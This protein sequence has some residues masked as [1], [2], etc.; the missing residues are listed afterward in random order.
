MKK[1][2]SNNYPTK[3][4]LKAKD[5]LV[6]A[7]DLQWKI[8][9]EKQR[10]EREAEGRAFRQKRE[11]AA[12]S[13]YAMAKQSGLAYST[14]QRYEQ[15]KYVTRR[16]VVKTTLENALTNWHLIRFAKAIRSHLP[17]V[18]QEVMDAAEKSRPRSH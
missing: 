12:L 3:M 11:A 16:K 18:W 8:K 2:T 9:L 10:P 4:N 5:N 1:Q 7:S 6:Q 14:I 15:G 13:V 17:A